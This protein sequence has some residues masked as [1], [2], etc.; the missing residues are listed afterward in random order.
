[1]SFV[2]AVRLVGIWPQKPAELTVVSNFNL[3][4]PSVTFS[5][6]VDHARF[7]RKLLVDCDNRSSDRGVY[8]RCRLD[9]LHA[10]KGVAHG[11]LV[12]DLR[13]VDEHNVAKR[14]L[15]KVSDTA[16]AYLSINL[17]IFMGYWYESANRTASKR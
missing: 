5:S 6:F 16:C 14:G 8:I 9:R 7:V 4:E 1:M 3:D 12:T 17:D 2:L 15:R 13:E 11:E 10:S